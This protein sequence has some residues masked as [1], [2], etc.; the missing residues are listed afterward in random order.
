MRYYCASRYDLQVA[1]CMA[2]AVSDELSTMPFRVYKWSL[3]DLQGKA[4][5][6]S[7][8]GH[9]EKLLDSLS[10]LHAYLQTML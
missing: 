5:C 6:V 8:P 7:S 2:K 3:L 9:G 10:E 4:F 1:Q